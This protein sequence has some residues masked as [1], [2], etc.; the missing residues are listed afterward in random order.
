MDRAYE[1]LQQ[2]FVEEL[3][4]ARD[5]ALA[6]WN[7]LLRAAPA[8]DPEAAH[9]QV[10]LRWPAGPVSYPRI[11]AVY[12]KCYLACEALN[13]TREA[14]RQEAAPAGWGEEDEDAGPPTIQP[15]KLLIESL[16]AADP[17]LAR[18]MTGFV[19]SPIGTDDEGRT[20]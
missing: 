20:A 10:R 3:K 17:E 6:W 1:E 5:A 13:E 2:Q 14:A 8:P 4:E 18:F 12:R 19:F 16:E 9:A 11:V 7:D 15:R